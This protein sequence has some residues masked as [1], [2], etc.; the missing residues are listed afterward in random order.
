MRAVDRIPDRFA[1]EFAGI[2]EHG[3]L[4][5]ARHGHPGEVAKAGE[6]MLAR[7]DQDGQDPR[8]DEKQR[9]REFGVRMNADGT[10]TPYGRFTSALCAVWNPIIDALAAPQPADHTSDQT[11]DETGGETGERDERTAGQRRHDGLLEAGQRLLRSG[12]LPDSGGVPVTVLAHLDADQLTTQLNAQL[13][14]QLAEQ[15]AEQRVADRRAQC[16]ELLPR[17]RQ[18]VQ[19]QAAVATTGHGDLIPIGEL[20]T[21]A[22]EAHIIPVVLN[23]SSGVLAYGQTRRLAS[24]GQR[25]ALAARDRGC[26]FPGCTRP[27]AWCEAHH[28]IPWYLGGPTDLDNLCLLC[29]Y[30][31]R[32][33]ERRGWHLRMTNGRPEWIP[34]PWLAPDQ[35]PRRNTAHHLT[36][37]D[38]DVGTTA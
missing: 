22:A 28:V 8:E 2:V 5:Q 36:D 32:E 19:A 21:L 25:H 27:P 30:H 17:L 37:F 38:F 16:D 11:G 4:A 24:C 12:T 10:G 29:A 26:V 33:F 20:L 3:L 7:I 18:H 9:R 35:Q 14:D 34:P 23:D 1:A 6:V 15:F 31:H 13:A